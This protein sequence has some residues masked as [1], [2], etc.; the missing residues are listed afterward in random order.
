M[1]G[2]NYYYSFPSW[3]LA[4]TAFLQTY[5][6]IESVGVMQMRALG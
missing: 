4:N 1:I 3:S 6:E 2:Y 5:E